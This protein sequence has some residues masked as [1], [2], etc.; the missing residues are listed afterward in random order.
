MPSVS[1]QGLRRLGA[2]L[3]AW[4]NRQRIRKG[5]PSCFQWEKETRGLPMVPGAH[6]AGGTGW[7]H[8][9]CGLM[10]YCDQQESMEIWQISTHATSGFH[11]SCRAMFT[12]SLGGRHVAR[13][14]SLV[15]LHYIRNTVVELRAQCELLRNVGPCVFGFA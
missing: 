8:S 11:I 12:A 13:F 9:V 10:R 15:Q 1:E 6:D 4:P 2:F 7:S 3:R 14:R 5:Y